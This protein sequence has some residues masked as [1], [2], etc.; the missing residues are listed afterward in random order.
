[1]SF[2]IIKANW[3]FGGINVLNGKVTILPLNQQFNRLLSQTIEN[4]VTLIL[5]EFSIFVALCKTKPTN[6]N[7]N[8]FKKFF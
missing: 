5:T 4:V 8:R 3:K 6:L 2:R 1:M 7:L